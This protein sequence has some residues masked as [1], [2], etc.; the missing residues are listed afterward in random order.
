MRVVRLMRPYLRCADRLGVV[1]G[2]ARGKAV[3]KT[4][5]SLGSEA[6]LPGPSDTRALLP[7]IGFA[8]VRSVAG[9][10]LWVWYTVTDTHVAV[11][12]RTADPPVPIS[13]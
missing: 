6:T 5:A 2:S 12:A 3:A 10:N 4:I 9:R 8:F 11:I 13:D 7:P 1:A